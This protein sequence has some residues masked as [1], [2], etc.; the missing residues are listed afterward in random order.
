MPSRFLDKITEWRVWFYLE[1]RPQDHLGEA[2][3]QERSDIFFEDRRCFFRC[4]FP[5]EDLCFT[6]TVANC[7]LPGRSEI[8]HPV[9]LPKSGEQV[10]AAVVFEQSY[11]ASSGLTCDSSF[12]S[13]KSYGSHR[14]P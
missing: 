8:A 9:D 3:L 11:W 4:Q 14:D 5:R 10:I 2:V 1:V 6:E 13:E 12:H 7:C